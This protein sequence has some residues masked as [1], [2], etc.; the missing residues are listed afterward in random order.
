MPLIEEPVLVSMSDDDEIALACR[1]FLDENHVGQSNPTALDVFKAG[2]AAGQASKQERIAELEKLLFD[3]SNDGDFLTKVSVE[4][5]KS[6][7]KYPSPDALSL[8]V[9]EEAGEVARALTKESAERVYDECVDLAIVAMRLA[10]EGDSFID[11]YRSDRGLDNTARHIG[12]D[13]DNA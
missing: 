4:V 13:D 7:R 9:A 8:A 6:R 1:K 2:Y 11:K 12:A 3:R 5:T 10:T